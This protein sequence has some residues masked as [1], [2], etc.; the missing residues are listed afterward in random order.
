MAEDIYKVSVRINGKNQ[1]IDINEFNKK[2]HNGYAKEYPDA[3][4]RMRNKDNE[5]F[6]IPLSDFVPM[7]HGRRFLSQNR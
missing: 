4:I 5:D 3:V 7:L 1:D 2:G 6:A